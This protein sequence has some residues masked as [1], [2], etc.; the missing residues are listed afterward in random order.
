MQ[1]DKKQVDFLKTMAELDELMKPHRVCI[2]ADSVEGRFLENRF[3]YE[4]NNCGGVIP[5]KWAKGYK[6]I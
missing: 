6:R 4:C 5:L 3:T 2:C 1:I